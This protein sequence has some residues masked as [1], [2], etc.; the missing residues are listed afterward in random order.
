VQRTV[1]MAAMD[2]NASSQTLV[3]TDA[4]TTVST[5]SA[6]PTTFNYLPTT[7]NVFD[8]DTGIGIDLS[9]TI[10]VAQTNSGTVVSN[11][12][13]QIY[14]DGAP[15]PSGGLFTDSSGTF[16]PDKRQF[17]LIADDVP[18]AGN[19]TYSIHFSLAGSHGGVLTDINLIFQQTVFKLRQYKR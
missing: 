17:A 9:G 12:T 11:V 16:Y 3:V 10:S 1:P 8:G 13:V 18:G 14:R 2:Q 4:G 5:L 19:H 15:L 7:L 6:S